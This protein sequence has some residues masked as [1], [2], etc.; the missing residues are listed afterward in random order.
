MLEASAHYT[1]NLSFLVI[2]IIIKCTEY[3]TVNYKITGVIPKVSYK[4]ALFDVSSSCVFILVFYIYNFCSIV[5]STFLMLHI[6]LLSANKNFLLTYLL[7]C[8]Y[9]LVLCG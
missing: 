2:I 1:I 7:I 8:T 5:F 4:T 6:C 3:Y 9:Q